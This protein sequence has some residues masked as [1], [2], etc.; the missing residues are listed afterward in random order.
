MRKQVCSFFKAVA[1]LICLA[2]AVGTVWA[3]SGPSQLNPDPC[4]VG[5]SAMKSVPIAQATAATTQLVAP[6]TTT[7]IYVCGISINSVGGTSQLEYGTGASCTGTHALTGTYAASSTVSIFPSHMTLL[8]IPA[9]STGVAP[10]GLCIVSGASTTATGG[11]ISY[12][13]Q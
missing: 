8:S 6:L 12:V 13:Q 1:V 3:Q 11:F 4:Q 10:N 9:D 5:Y 7:A 2:V